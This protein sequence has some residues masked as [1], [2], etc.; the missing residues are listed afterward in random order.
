M[1][2]DDNFCW[3][4][5][6]TLW[7]MYAH[8]WQCHIVNVK[9]DATLGEKLLL[10]FFHTSRHGTPAIILRS[11]IHLDSSPSTAVSYPSSK[12]PVRLPHQLFTQTSGLCCVSKSGCLSWFSVE[13]ISLQG[14][15][16]W[17][18]F[19][20]HSSMDVVVVH[21]SPVAFTSSPFCL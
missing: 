17:H 12:V 20:F 5:L 9:R 15:V 3:K 11:S 10:P 19:Y 14:C 1:N 18:D 13:W 16:W 4:Y 6:L 21:Q 2:T 7:L 8:T